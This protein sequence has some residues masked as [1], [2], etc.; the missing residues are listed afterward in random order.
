[1]SHISLSAAVLMLGLAGPALAQTVALP[2]LPAV[3]KPGELK[4]SSRARAR[5]T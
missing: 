3:L 1:M 4:P 2:D 5:G